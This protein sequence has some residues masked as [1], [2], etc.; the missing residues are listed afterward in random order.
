LVLIQVSET[1]RRRNAARVENVF[2]MGRLR[3]APCR[4]CKLS[5]EPL[6]KSQ[7]KRLTRAEEP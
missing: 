3:I 4:P 2:V 5:S 7:D 6:K 1:T